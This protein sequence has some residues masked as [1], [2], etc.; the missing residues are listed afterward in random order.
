M[1]VSIYTTMKVTIPIK[2]PVSTSTS[3]FKDILWE[4][5]S[6]FHDAT[7]FSNSNSS[8]K[9]VEGDPFTLGATRTYH[10]CVTEKVVERNDQSMFI[11]W[12]RVDNSS[13]DEF[14]DFEASIKVND[15]EIVF[16]LQ[17]PNELVSNLQKFILTRLESV[18]SDSLVT[19]NDK[20]I[21][22]QHIEYLDSYTK[23]LMQIICKRVL[24]NLANPTAS[25]VIKEPS[26]V[27]Q[28]KDQI[29]QFQIGKCELM[30]LKKDDFF[31]EAT[32]EEKASLSA[33]STNFPITDIFL[34]FP[35]H[36]VKK[37]RAYYPFDKCMR[38]PNHYAP[39]IQSDE[40]ISR[41]AFYGG[42][43]LWIKDDKEI[44]SNKEN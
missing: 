5:L 6:N 35:A 42:I 38:V 28:G 4:K 22:D 9:S 37:F 13:S 15:N 43:S 11:R 17:G 21:M 25:A 24:Q 19:E 16:T 7:W 39:E 8:L 3:D 14:K 1:E 26:L 20:I 36:L 31:G 44:D 10:S 30:M 23:L 27:K 32:A 29:L 33:L 41:I 34:D 2:S 12:M 40:S 18:V